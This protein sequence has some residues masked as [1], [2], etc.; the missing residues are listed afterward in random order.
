MAAVLLAGGQKGRRY[1]LSHAKTMIHEPLIS[2]GVGGSPTSIK[3]I[4]DSILETK[5]LVNSI[6]VKHTGKTAEKID[7]AT[8]TLTL[9][10]QKCIH[11]VP[12]ADEYE[13]ADK[14]YQLAINAGNNVWM[15][16]EA[17]KEYKA[18]LQS[19]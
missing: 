16:K 11:M 3:N 1:I 8:D 14:Y 4:S 17:A 2:N 13:E 19:R 9:I 15:N 5:R 6:M 12:E 18:Y 7:E 10:W